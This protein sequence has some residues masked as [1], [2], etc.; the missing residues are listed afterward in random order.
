M[1][2]WGCIFLLYQ[3]REQFINP[4]VVSSMSCFM[5]QIWICSP[6][7][8]SC[9]CR[10][11]LE[12]DRTGPALLFVCSRRFQPSLQFYIYICL[13]LSRLQKWITSTILIRSNKTLT[14]SITSLLRITR[15][16]IVMQKTFK[17]IWI[18]TKRSLKRKN[19]NRKLHVK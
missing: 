17:I 1:S 4:S 5:S 18:I 6:L 3:K 8:S 19:P 12:R 11:I 14:L 9:Y 13:N 15:Q 7:L 2:F 16:S 10:S